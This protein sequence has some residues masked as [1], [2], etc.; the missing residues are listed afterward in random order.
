MIFHEDFLDD[1]WQFAIARTW[2]LK[3]KPFARYWHNIAKM[4]IRLLRRI[5]PLLILLYEGKARRLINTL[6]KSTLTSAPMKNADMT[7]AVIEDG[8]M[9]W[10]E[11]LGILPIPRFRCH[12]T[13]ATT[14]NFDVAIMDHLIPFASEDAYT[15]RPN[16]LLTKNRVIRDFIKRDRDRSEFPISKSFYFYDRSELEFLVIFAKDYAEQGRIRDFLTEVRNND[17]WIEL[18]PEV[19]KR[20]G[21]LS[22]DHYSDIEFCIRFYTR[23]FWHVRLEIP[24]TY[25]RAIINADSCGFPLSNRFAYAYLLLYMHTDITKCQD[26]TMSEQHYKYIGILGREMIFHAEKYCIHV[27]QMLKCVMFKTIL[28]PLDSIS[29]WNIFIKGE[30]IIDMI[31]EY[32]HFLGGNHEA[33][34]PSRKW[35]RY[36]DHPHKKWEDCVADMQHSRHAVPDDITCTFK[37]IDIMESNNLFC[38]SNREIQDIIVTPT[39]ID[40]KKEFPNVLEFIAQVQNR[41]NQ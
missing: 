23:F 8:M 1:F 5:L 25:A 14:L 32:H 31:K 36:L 21:Y 35:I 9:Y 22:D 41:N 6:I 27:A 28:E 12:E 2:I 30:R 37:S 34:H 13:L 26:F 24:V 4:R 40:V 11:M 17:A 15:Y 38:P 3:E 20:I 10:K 33:D 29:T 18:I 19:L 39:I 7:M 16:Y